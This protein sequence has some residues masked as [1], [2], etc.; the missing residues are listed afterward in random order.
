HRGGG[1]GGP[2]EASAGRAPLTLVLVLDGLRPD[3]ITAEETPNLWRLRRE[4][5]DFPN[6]HAVFP[7]VTRVNATA[8][9]TGAYPVRNGIFGNRIYVRAFD[10]N[11]AFNNDD[12][13]A[14]LRLDDVTGGGMVLAK[15]PGEL[16]AE[17]GK[18][19]A[20]GS[21]RSPRT[22]AVA[23]SRAPPGGGGASQRL[24]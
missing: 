5:V 3:S 23:Q 13:R 20:A 2:T 4:G 7:T 9:A 21:S 16:M 14:L 18:R 12:H 15:T 11:N 8:I 6:S 19:L 10:P 22:G 1:R 17:R 24:L